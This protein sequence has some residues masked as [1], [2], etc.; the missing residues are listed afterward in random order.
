MVVPDRHPHEKGVHHQ[1]SLTRA[2]VLAGEGSDA[3]GSMPVSPSVMHAAMT[4]LHEESDVL[5]DPLSASERAKNPAVALAWNGPL[6][7]A[8]L[9]RAARLSDRVIVVVSSGMPAIELSKVTTRLGREEGVGYVL[10]NLADEYADLEDRVGNVEAFW[11]GSAP[12]QRLGTADAQP[13][14]RPTGR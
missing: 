5:V 13:G 1:P 4:V 12:G 6:Q 8:V 7:G 2:V 11:H 10:V 9:R 3:E 14:L